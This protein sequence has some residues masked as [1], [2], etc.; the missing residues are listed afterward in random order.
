[1]TIIVGIAHSGKVYMAGDRGMSDKE[2]IGSIITPKIHKVGPILMGYSASQG[3]GQ[4]AHLVTY[5]KPV[6]ENL[7]AWL[8]ID[9]CDAIQKAA[10]LFKIDINTED[11]GADF[12]VGVSGRLFEISTVDWSVSEYET[13]ATGSGFSYA[14]GSLFST[15]DWDSPRNRVREAVKA[16]ITYSPS[17][18]GPIDTLVL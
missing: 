8:R 16:S 17:C 1:V 9:F 18:Q 10:E 12:L 7:E 14:M 15:R 11:N 4:L 13:I 3:T 6:Y 5:P 2:F